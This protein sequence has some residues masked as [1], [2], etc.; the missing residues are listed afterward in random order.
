MRYP[1][2]RR[3][4][5]RP[6]QGKAQPESPTDVCCSLLPRNFHRSVR[7]SCAADH[8]KPR[9]GSPSTLQRN[10]AFEHAHAAARQHLL[11]GAVANFPLGILA[12]RALIGPVREPDGP[13][14]LNVFAVYDDAS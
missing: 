3:H 5:H 14:L 1:G 8:I 2:D 11:R 4:R 7:P 13:P 10:T 6:R 12:M 9:L